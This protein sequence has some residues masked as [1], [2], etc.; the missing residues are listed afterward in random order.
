MIERSKYVE[1]VDDW[2]LHTL[3][4]ANDRLLCAFVSLRLITC[5]HCEMMTTQYI[6]HQRHESLQFR[7]LLRLLDRQII[8]WQKRWTEKVSGHGED[9]H[10]FL[11]PFYGSYARLLLFTSAL[12]ASMRLRDIVTSVDT[13][14]IWNSCSSALDML[15]LVSEPPASQSVYFAQDS[16]HVMIAYA[17]VFLIK[18]HTS[19][20]H[21]ETI[22]LTRKQLLVSAPTYIQDEMELPAL[23]S[24]RNTAE[25]FATLRAPNDTSCSL[26]A[27][28]LHNALTEYEIVKERR[29][30]LR[31]EI[32]AAPA[33]IAI[34][35]S[36]HPHAQTVQ[37]S[38]FALVRDHQ[39]L[40]FT[41]GDASTFDLGF[42]NDEAWALIFA[43]AGFNVDQGAF[44]LP[45]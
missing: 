26:Q 17:T 31:S 25:I 29:T 32:P 18:V 39:A 11:I 14:A 7:S 4:T 43:N 19:R 41:S 37:G 20:H 21:Y 45:T 28:F 35:Q 30:P 12:R 10:T 13:E 24:I 2:Y 44:V 5:T 36:A 16:V 8:D 22:L 38:D 34:S 23:D 15:K 27:A 42:T 3:E 1:S 9:C 33:D 6:Q 40:S